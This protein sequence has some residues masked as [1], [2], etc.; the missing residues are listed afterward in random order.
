MDSAAARA[1]PGTARTLAPVDARGMFDTLG[2][3]LE[4]IRLGEDAGLELE[5][6]RFGGE[7]VSTPKWTAL[8]DHLRT[9]QRT[10]NRGTR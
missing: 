3:L 10:P 1:Q 5:T 9:N 2:E 8:A 7:S 4:K 6:V